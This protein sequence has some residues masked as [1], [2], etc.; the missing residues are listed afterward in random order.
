MKGFK[1]IAIFFI[2]LLL[3]ISKTLARTSLGETP[4][5][6]NFAITTGSQQIG[7]LVSLGQNIID[8]DTGLLMLSWSDFSGPKNHLINLTPSILWAFSD[9]FSVYFNAPY[10]VD[11]KAYG[12]HSSGLEDVYLQFEYA[13]YNTVTSSN[14]KQATIIANVTLPTGEASDIPET[15]YGSVS[16]LLGGTFNY[17][18]IDWYM[19]TSYG[20]FLTTEHNKTRFGNQYYYQ[21]G[22]A[23]NIM[24]IPNKLIF[25]FMLEI[26]GFYLEKDKID[27]QVN[28]N[29][30]GNVVYV[31]PS[32]W[33]SSPTIY[34][35]LGAGV[36]ITQHWNGHQNRENYLL[37]GSFG[38]AF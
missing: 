9:D 2:V 12:N 4:Q 38:L 18:G 30:G 25:D 15:G 24:G 6:G 16:F 34:L 20:A 1:K 27:G 3:S 10:A 22:L 29:T 23:K 33:V 17:T 36:P 21:A 8:A 37:L 35:Q 13:Y 26:D 7:P 5:L 14:A 31:T 11:Y 28:P 19:F 32:I